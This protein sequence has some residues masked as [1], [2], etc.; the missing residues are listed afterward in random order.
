MKVIE[1]KDLVKKY[2]DLIAVD[3]IN[4][5]IEKGEIYGLLGPNGA[6]K[7]TLI[8]IISSLLKQTSGTVKVFGIDTRKNRTFTNIYK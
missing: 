8:S 4:L 1:I 6:G 5:S 2:D 3:N 7:S